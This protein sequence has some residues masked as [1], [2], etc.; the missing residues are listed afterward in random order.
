MPQN[1]SIKAT[2]VQKLRKK[3]TYAFINDNSIVHILMPKNNRL[4]PFQLSFNVWIGQVRLFARMNRIQCS[5]EPS[6]QTNKI[7]DEIIE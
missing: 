4:A 7:G 3:D 5:I 1:A 2:L 6:S